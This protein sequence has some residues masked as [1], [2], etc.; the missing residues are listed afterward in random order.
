MTS[1][2]EMSPGPRPAPSPAWEAT[3]AEMRLAVREALAD[4]GTML[5]F[6]PVIGVVRQAPAFHEGLIRIRD[7]AGRVLPAGRFLP[8]IEPTELGREVDVAALRHGLDALADHPTL[9][10]SINMSARSIDYPRWTE[11]LRRGLA[12]DPTAAERLILE[13]TES[14]A[15]LVPERVR[16]FMRELQDEGI[17]FAL[18]DFGA[19][20]TCFRYLRDFYFDILKVD[21]SFT[22]GCDVD[23]DGQCILQAMLAIGKQFEMLTVAEAVETAAE[24]RFLAGAGFDCLQG[25]HCGMPET[26]PAWMTAPE[27][28]GRDAHRAAG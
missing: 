16:S 2:V 19:G 14:S 15:M 3:D 7:R 23:A 24:A 20:Q 27:G 9:R 10:L 5:A 6:Q 25:F 8:A 4:G 26:Q 28:E 1:E 11:A 17:C 22:R 12:V 13:V 21:G 18:D